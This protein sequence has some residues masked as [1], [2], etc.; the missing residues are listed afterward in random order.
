MAGAGV[1]DNV[2]SERRILFGDALR[3]ADFG[4]QFQT[5]RLLVDLGDGGHG[6]G[7]ALAPDGRVGPRTGEQ[8]TDW[9]HRP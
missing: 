4:R 3:V 2:A 5:A 8:Y 7:I 9:N 1:P 6:A